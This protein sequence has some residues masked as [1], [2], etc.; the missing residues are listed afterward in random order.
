[1]PERALGSS[2]SGQ[3][4]GQRA[5]RGGLHA[6]VHAIDAGKSRGPVRQ[7]SGGKGSNP[8]GAPE[9]LALP[10]PGA[11]RVSSSR[12][13]SSPR[14]HA[15]RAHGRAGCNTACT[16]ANALLSGSSQGEGEGFKGDKGLA[17]Y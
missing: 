16:H 7:F 2:S 12:A 10:Q 17:P 15:I 13:A 3:A 11:T 1:M 14:M 6:Y 4:A 9:V 5:G 8:Q